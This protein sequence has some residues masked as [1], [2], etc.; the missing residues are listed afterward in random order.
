[1][2]EN[3]ILTQNAQFFTSNIDITDQMVNEIFDNASDNI[4][5]NTDFTFN[6]IR[7]E[8]RTGD[9]EFTY[10]YSIRIYPSVRDVYFLGDTDLFDI[11]YSYILLLEFGRK[12]VIFKKST[13]NVNDI[14]QRHFNLVEHSSMINTFDDDSVE[15]Q[16]MALRNMTVSD[17]AVRAKTYEAAD[18]K[19]VLSVHAAG[20]SIPYF[21]RIRHGDSLKTIATTTGR[22]VESS[23]RRGIDDL[24]VWAKQQTV[25]LNRTSSKT[26]LD[27]F[28]SPVVLKD[29]LLLTQPK[30]ILVEASALMDRIIRDALALKRISK[31]RGAIQLNP[32]IQKKL[33][34]QLEQVFEIDD[35]QNILGGPPNSKLKVNDKT[36]TFNSKHLKQI[37]IADKGTDITLQN[38]LIRYGL[39]SVCFGNPKYMYY[40]GNCFE[41]RSG[42][43][44]I[45][46]ILQM[47]VIKNEISTATSEKGTII[48]TSIDFEAVSVFKIVEDIHAPDDYIFCDDL[49]NEWADHIT[50]NKV[51]TCISF[52]H[53]KHGDESTSASNLHDVVGQGI[54]N[55]GNMFFTKSTFMEKKK[56]KLIQRYNRSGISRLRKGTRP[57]LNADL[58]GI[59]GSFKIN[60]K[61]ILCCTFLSKSGVER[62][63]RKIQRGMPVSGHIIQLLWILSSFAHAAKEMNVIPLIYCK[64]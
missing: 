3:L 38:Y 46:N 49:G 63:F 18:L 7:T 62:E 25:L 44:Q 43:S 52:I 50:F 15:F 37:L 36:I 14:I 13:S 59:L 45:Q 42:I 22:I 54:K 27:A 29:V 11:I 20:K 64:A 41:D 8:R 58:E 34:K 24:A 21:L 30:A 6:D 56:T 5:A 16:K 48:P 51:D 47:F 57:G 9:P 35:N 39:Y 33:F 40:M 31:A 53:S 1:M 55:L 10:N 60:R 12:V 61:C 19:G 23:E 17:R 32:E 26:F 2:V 4:M 28:A